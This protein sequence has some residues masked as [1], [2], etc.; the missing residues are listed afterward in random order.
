MHRLKT[1][2]LA[3]AL[4]GLADGM[5]SAAHAQAGG[6]SG[7]LSVDALVRYFDTIV[8]GSEIN[9]AYANRVVAKWPK[10][11][12]TVS[13]EKRATQQ[14]LGFVSAHLKAL[15]KLTGKKFGG[16]KTAESADIRI[17]FL[18]RDEMANIRGDNIDARAVL[19]GA[20]SGGCYFLSW[21]KPDEDIV[22]AIVV[23]NVERDAALINS[24][25]LEELTQS[26][27][28][29]ND[30]DM[31]R[32][33]IFSDRDHLTELSPQ[34][35]ILVRTLYDPRMTAGLPRTEALKVARTIISDLPT[36]AR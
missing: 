36:P 26:L 20:M 3:L 28:L 7:S 23:V 16:S 34:D 6:K 24:C 31:L 14:H 33:S 22:K 32:P 27:G 11:L 21:K 13:L 15:A 5:P 1:L 30:S 12:I 18:K 8:F 35:Q 2:L 25:L 29:P 19:E 17:L 9:P 4:V 10:N